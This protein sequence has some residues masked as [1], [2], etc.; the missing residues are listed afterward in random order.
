MD[1]R[2]PQNFLMT[3]YQWV[4]IADFALTTTSDNSVM[5][6]TTCLIEGRNPANGGLLM[7]LQDGITAVIPATIYTCL[8]F[9]P[10]DVKET[11]SLPDKASLLGAYPNP[12]NSSTSVKFVLPS[13]GNVS[14]VIYNVNGQKVRIFKLSNQR[15]GEG[16]VTWDGADKS[17]KP[18][19][20]GVYV[21]EMK[22][23]EFKATS[24]V[25]LIK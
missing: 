8:V 7:G 14:I 24:R 4:H 3:G 23:G 17:G 25:T 6:D 22:A 10:S 16:S 18:V 19:A 13:M 20:S 15:A 5:G 11:G 1:P 9:S 2:D 12:F 21:I